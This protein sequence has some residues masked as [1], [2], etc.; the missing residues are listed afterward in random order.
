MDEGKKSLLRRPRES[1]FSRK[2]DV[3]DNA[4]DDG[5][6]QSHPADEVAKVRERPV[7]RPPLR[8]A[9]ARAAEIRAHN[10][11]DV[12]GTDEFY[13]P[14]GDVPEGWG[15]QW[16]RQFT[17]GKEDPAYMVAVTRK[18]WEPVPTSRHPSYMP[19]GSTDPYITRKGMILMEMPQDL[20]DEAN[21]AELRRAKL[22]V[23]NKEEQLSAAP[24]GQF[25]RS[26]K[27][28]PMTKVKKSYT[29]MPIPESEVSSHCTGSQTGAC[30]L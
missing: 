2:P 10:I 28:D 12:E 24:P 14:P 7:S 1:I 6:I 29:P 17:M 9:K 5:E 26:N 11:D 19:R 30:L 18:G 27:D 13:I 3:V 8:D 15:Y 22:Q 4:P 25:E 16:K 20:I 23:R 21:A